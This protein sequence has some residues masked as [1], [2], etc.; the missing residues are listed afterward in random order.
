MTDVAIVPYAYGCAAWHVGSDRAPEPCRARHKLRADGGVE[1]IL[2]AGGSITEAEAKRLAWALLADL[3]PDE[4]IAVPEVVT[5]AEGSRLEILRHLAS[6]P[7]SIHDLTRLSG[8]KRRTVERKLYA[9]RGD[10]RVVIELRAGE[11]GLAHWKLAPA[12]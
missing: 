3:A 7:K 12:P 4:V 9:L 1:I 5:Y 2:P 6:G 10:G 11:G 8:W